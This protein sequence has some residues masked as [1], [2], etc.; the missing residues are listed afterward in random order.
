MHTTLSDG[1]GTSEQIARD[2]DRAGIEVVVIT[3]HEQIN[4]CAGWRGRCLM[5]SGY[6]VTPRRNHTLI[7][8]TDKTLPKFRGNGIDG[9]PARTLAA[10]KQA[11][12]FSVMAHP[13]DPP[14]GLFADSNS[15]AATDFSALD[16]DAIELL[17]CIS[18]FKRATHGAITGLKGILFP[19]TY[20]AGPHPLELSLWDAVGRSRRW[21]AI[22]GADAHAFPTRR[23]WLPLTLY[24][25]RR[26]MR[27]TTTG[28]W[29]NGP[30]RGDYAHDRDLVLEALKAGRCFCAVGNARG[31]ACTFKTASG[32][33]L[34]PG[35]E[36]PFTPGGVIRVSLPGRGLIRVM[37]NGREAAHRRG[38]TLEFSPG[39][40][41]IW[42]VEARRRRWPNGDRPWIYCNPFYLR[43]PEVNP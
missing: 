12:A 40:P 13:L 38:R 25:Y 43:W 10:A 7:L 3:D 17:N 14:L 36:E 19:L 29:L 22:G 16:Y 6:E 41:G 15:Y 32:G 11:G 28:L 8:G 4:D 42:R 26:H 18:Q 30:F 24:S 34:W 35:S 2:A 39:G 27:L 31:F 33:V 23:K 37:H 5:L 20:L 1:H 21:T 9:D